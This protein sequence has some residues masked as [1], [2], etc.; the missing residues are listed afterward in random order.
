DEYRNALDNGL[1][2]VKSLVKEPNRE[3]FVDWRPYL[4]HAWTARHD[5]RFDLKTLQDLSAKLLEIPEGFV[6]QRQ[7]AKIYEDRQKMQAGG[8]PIN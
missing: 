6:V 3:L 8:L 5:T 7:V 4:G 1:H 2:V